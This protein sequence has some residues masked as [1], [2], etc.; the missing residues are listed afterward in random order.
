MLGDQLLGLI[1]RD[2][3]LVG[4]MSNLV[5]LAASDKARSRPCLVVSSDMILS[6]II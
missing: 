1:D 6:F 5:F 2:A 4:E 3:V